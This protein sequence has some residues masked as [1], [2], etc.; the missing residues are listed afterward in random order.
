MKSTK[1]A[2][3]RALFAL[4]AFAVICFG[5]TGC[6]QEDDEDEQTG[7]VPVSISQAPALVGTWTSTYGEIF[8]ITENSLSNGGSWG[9]CYAGNELK[10][11]KLSDTA[12]YIYIKYTRAA[13]PDFTYSETAP[14]VGKWYAI[15]YSDLSSNSV[16]LSGAYKASGKTSMPTLAEAILEFTVAN[17]YFASSSICS[18]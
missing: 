16:K 10:I 7:S 14:D 2:F 8:A 17:G 1:F 3:R 12:G 5:F 15:F 9:D 13:N 11:I 6:Q 4:A 18:K